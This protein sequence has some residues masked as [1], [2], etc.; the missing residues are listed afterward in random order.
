MQLPNYLVVFSLPMVRQVPKRS[1]VT[2]PIPI[3]FSRALATPGEAASLSV[4][5]PVLLLPQGAIF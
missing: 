5:A 4:N 2:S 1:G 3:H